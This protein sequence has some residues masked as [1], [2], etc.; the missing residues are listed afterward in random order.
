M[1]GTSRSLRRKPSITCF[2]GG[3]SPRGLR[4]MNMR[5]A[6]CVLL[7]P[8]LNEFTVATFGS[9]RKSSTTR[10][11]KRTM[12]SNEVSSDASVDTLIWPMSSSGKNPLGMATNMA[13]VPA[14]VSRATINTT[15][16]WRRA[17]SRLRV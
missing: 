9:A 14:N 4:L 15:I 1:P 16:R 11:C 12:S 7:L 2:M 5:P 13:Q 6:F 17:R 10:F 3:R 8:P